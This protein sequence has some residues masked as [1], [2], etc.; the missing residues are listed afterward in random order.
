MR[1]VVERLTD[2]ELEALAS[3]VSGLN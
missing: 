2:K 3:Y 1:S